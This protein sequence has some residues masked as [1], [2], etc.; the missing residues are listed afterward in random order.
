MSVDTLPPTASAVVCPEQSSWL[1]W[2]GDREDPEALV[3]RPDL[4]AHL[5]SCVACKAAVDEV[6]R[7]Q[8]LL[9]RA[10]VP[11]L[12]PEQRQA[13]E[14]RVRMMAGQWV[15]PPRVSPKVAWGM[16]L[17]AAAVLV[18]LVARPFVVRRA[19]HLEEFSRR[20]A[21]AT[22]PATDRAFA[23]G[24]AG[25]GVLTGAVEGGV[26]VA[27]RD[28]AWRAMAPGER[29]RAG[30]R[31]RTD[32]ASGRVMVP[33]RFE[34]RLAPATE[35]EVLAVSKLDEGHAPAD[36][37]FRLRAGEVDCTVEKLL[38]TQHFVVMFAG[39][40]ASVVGT[41]FTVQHTTSSAGVQVQVSEGAVR[42]DQ[43]DD[44]WKAPSSD[45]MTTVRA[46][47]RWHYDAGRMALEPI[48]LP[49]NQASVQGNQGQSPVKVVAP[50]PVAAPVIADV[51]VAEPVAVQPSDLQV[52]HGPAQGHGAA[53]VPGKDAR[54]TPP[55]EANRTPPRNFLIEVPPQEM[56]PDEGLPNK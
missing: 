16:A 17:C 54:L 36:G 34:L 6:R 24:Q 7:Y 35:L 3:R 33:G 1:E 46:G 13:I 48:P 43:S 29:L 38:P 22:L 50:A 40:R 41:R 4:Q 19:E 51:P 42:V 20:L 32:A 28:G 53:K 27:D 11:G 47:N 23:P 52:N 14:E 5:E 12:S 18:A 45:T 8:T 9:L 44:W 31:L 10:R 39:F 26:Q 30:M 49:G 55:A 15:P 56:S 37:A 25:M 21:E 2:L